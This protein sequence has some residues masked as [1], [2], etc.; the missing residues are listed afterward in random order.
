MENEKSTEYLMN[1]LNTVT[2]QNF[3]SYLK[4]PEVDSRTNLSKYLLEFLG[5]K[6]LSQADVIKKS[7]LSRG[8]ANNIFNGNREN[9][10]REKLLTLCVACGMNVVETNRAL[11]LAKVSELYAKNSR[12]AAIIV[13]LNNGYDIFDVNIFLEDNGM[14]L[15][16]Y[17]D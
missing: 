11:K 12:D 16:G 13:C 8:Y 17:E 15:L 2:A 5:K 1:K 9:P 10:S 3:K 4:E 7:G 14:S 6:D